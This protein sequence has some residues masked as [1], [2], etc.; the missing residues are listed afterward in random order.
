MMKDGPDSTSPTSWRRLLLIPTAARLGA[1]APRDRQVG[2]DRFWDDVGSTGDGGDVL[3]D[4]SNP[5]E[6]TRYLPIVLEHLDHRLPVVDVGCGNGR[7]ARML[8]HHFPEVLGVDLSPMALD[9]AQAESRGVDNLRFQSVD[10]TV[11]GAGRVLAELIGPA[12]VFVRGV[13]HIFS[14]QDRI[15]VA[16][17]LREVLGSQ[18]RLFLTETNYPGDSL[19][20][21][22]HLGARPGKVPIPLQRA[23]QR[24]PKPRPFG[25]VEREACLPEAQWLL[26]A[27]GATEVYTIPLQ[28][29]RDSE[30]IPGYYA[31]LSP[32]RR[33]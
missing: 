7:Q 5:G 4:T 28:R 24:L 14:A 17:N 32:R 33:N 25:S 29:G 1:S 8:A 27:E 31:V 13:F 19:S 12:N 30:V 9:R 2:W 6:M 18:G 15:A 16:A 22:R 10:L 26:H 20:Y 21:L 3:W 23:I 11:S